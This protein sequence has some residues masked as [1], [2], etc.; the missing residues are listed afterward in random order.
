MKKVLTALSLCL[1]CM[2]VSAQSESSDEQE[3]KG[4]TK[5]ETTTGS[6]LKKGSR[7]IIEIGGGLGTEDSKNNFSINLTMGY[8]FAP[9][10]FMGLGVG[11]H[12]HT[13]YS[14]YTGSYC[15]GKDNKFA[16]PI[17]LDLRS[18]FTDTRTTPF[19]DVKMG[20]SPVDLSGFYASFSIGARF[21]IKDS[22]NLSVSTGIERQDAD[23]SGTTDFFLRAGVDF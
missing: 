21:R 20:Y 7:N 18:D 1:L 19:I 12:L 17:F 5:T 16:L 4:K 14:Y 15:I 8:Q 3:V 9:Y 2:T 6:G 13:N 11:G 22:H 10:F 23:P